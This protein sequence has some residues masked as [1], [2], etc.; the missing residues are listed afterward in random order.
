MV[1]TQRKCSV[2]VGKHGEIREQGGACGVRK[3][4]R[5]RWGTR[6]KNCSGRGE[7]KGSPAGSGKRLLNILLG[8][9]ERGDGVSWKGGGEKE[10]W[11]VVCGG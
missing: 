10:G 9:G 7:G 4:N 1:E 3:R 8:K 2:G 5:K 6:E 11:Q